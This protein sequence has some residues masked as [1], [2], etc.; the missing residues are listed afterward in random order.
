MAL[1]FLALVPFFIA[2]SAVVWGFAGVAARAWGL[3]WSFKIAASLTVG[4][5]VLLLPCYA[6]WLRDRDG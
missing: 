4:V 2:L 5:H 3:P 6:V 1:G